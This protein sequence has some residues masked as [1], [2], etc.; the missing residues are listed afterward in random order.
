MFDLDAAAEFDKDFIGRKDG[1][2]F[3]KLADD[4]FIPPVDFLGA[5]SDDI[6]LDN[7]ERNLLW[8]PIAVLMAFKIAL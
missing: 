1:H 7:S 2:A 6:A 5:S 3:H 8:S 4:G